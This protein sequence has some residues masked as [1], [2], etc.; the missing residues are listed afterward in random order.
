MPLATSCCLFQMLNPCL[1]RC[2][3]LPMTGGFHS[4]PPACN[5]RL[6]SLD[7]VLWKES[8]LQDAGGLIIFL[9]QGADLLPLHQVLYGRA[10][11][12]L[13]SQTVCGYGRYRAVESSVA[14]WPASPCHRLPCAPTDIFTL[15]SCQSVRRP[16]QTGPS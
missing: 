15:A 1:G 3:R 12:L 8:A 9:T 14:T 6:L 13:A 7:R 10:T 4:F 2:A 11:C 5:P 16:V